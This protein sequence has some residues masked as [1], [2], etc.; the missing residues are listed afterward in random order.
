MDTRSLTRALTAALAAPAL[1]RA[2]SPA[3]VRQLAIGRCPGC[4]MTVREDD[5]LGLIDFRVAHA[6]CSLVRARRLQSG[7]R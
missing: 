6:E 5:V 7:R 3:Q 2:A 4:G 1:M